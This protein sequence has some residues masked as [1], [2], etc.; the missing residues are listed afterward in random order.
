MH[1][2]RDANS[3]KKCHTRSV[4]GQQFVKIAS[5]HSLLRP[6]FAVR[7]IHSFWSQ[8]TNEFAHNQIAQDWQLRRRHRSFQCRDVTGPFS[9]VSMAGLLKMCFVVVRINCRGRLKLKNY[10]AQFRRSLCLLMHWRSGKPHIYPLRSLTQTHTQTDW[11]EKK[12]SSCDQLW[13]ED[14]E[15]MDGGGEKETGEETSARKAKAKT[16]RCQINPLH[17]ST[18]NFLQFPNISFRW[19]VIIIHN[20]SAGSAERYESFAVSPAIGTQLCT[21]NAHVVHIA[22]EQQLGSG[23]SDPQH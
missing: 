8:P 19:G 2:L 5:S 10:S 21:R 6:L 1:T 18:Q 16:S 4:F 17:R 23:A 12:K 11:A 15:M 13:R 7:Q 14:N 20:D 22:A 3:T 9:L